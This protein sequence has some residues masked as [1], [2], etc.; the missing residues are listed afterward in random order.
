MI[1]QLLAQAIFTG[2][3]GG[4]ASVTARNCSVARSGAGI[5]AIT[6]GTGIDST[7]LQAKVRVSSATNGTT[8]KLVDTSDTVKTL[9]MYDV[10]GTAVTDTFSI[11]ISFYRV[12][13]G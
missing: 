4:P 7:Q 8:W 6:L 11:S 1:N 10:V 13:G 5:Y 12:S 2:N 9:T 3:A